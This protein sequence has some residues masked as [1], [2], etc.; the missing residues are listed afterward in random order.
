VDELARCD[1]LEQD[2]NL[3]TTGTSSSGVPGKLERNLIAGSSSSSMTARL[4]GTSSFK[5]MMRVSYMTQQPLM[6]PRPLTC[7]HSR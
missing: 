1:L 5:G 2:L 4:K 3:A 6:R 7:F